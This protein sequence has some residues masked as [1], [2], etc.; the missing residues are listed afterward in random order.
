MK[1]LLLLGAG[2][3][4]L[5]ALR[6]MARRP[7]EGDVLTMLV[8]PS[9]QAI[10]PALVSGH[11]AGHYAADD[12]RIDLPPLCH[13]AACNWLRADI[14]HLDAG[15]RRVH[16]LD[17]R[18]LEYDVLSIDAE[19]EID[20]DLLPGAARH[21]IFARPLPALIDAWSR[22]PEDAGDRDLTC[23]VVIG[24]GLAAVEM[25]LAARQRLGARAHICLVTQGGPVAPGLAPAA[26]RRVERALDRGDILRVQERCVSV[27]EHYIKLD[28]GM[29]LA[30]DVPIVATGDRAPGWLA[31]SGLTLDEH[32]A[33]HTGADLQSL[34]HL[35]VFAAGATG[36]CAEAAGKGSRRETNLALVR[37]LRR[38]L[39][40]GRADAARSGLAGIELVDCGERRAIASWGRWAAEGEWVWRVKHL[41]DR[42]RV[43]SFDPA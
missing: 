35:E 28:S 33:V 31:R 40:E 13:A 24:D 19:P 12:C 16:L 38:Y 10:Y 9:E 41:L 7:I 18:R 6:D 21:A 5:H 30:C 15:A 2:Q 29:Q 22:V 26:R 14:V 25:A 43:A 42:R 4:H 11:V 32:G 20:R 37:N 36:V 17:G 34:S 23:V 39:S 1:R 3:A 27:E 8:A